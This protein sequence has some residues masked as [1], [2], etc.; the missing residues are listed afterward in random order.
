MALSSPLYAE[1]TG[2]WLR[3]I[4]GANGNILRRPVDTPFGNI[5]SRVFGQA[6]FSSVT[7][8]NQQ[9][10]GYDLSWVNQSSCKQ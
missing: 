4:T 7:E 9:E 10:V 2:N 6:L 8:N 1:Q 3:G 5:L